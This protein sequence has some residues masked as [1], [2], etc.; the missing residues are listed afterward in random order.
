MWI[1]GVAKPCKQAIRKA[2]EAWVRKI[3]NCTREERSRL[4]KNFS[5]K[6]NE[7]QNKIRSTYKNDLNFF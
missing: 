5:L 6:G 1:D 2:N 3:K 4:L 7:N